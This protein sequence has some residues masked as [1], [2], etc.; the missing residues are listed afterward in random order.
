MASGLKARVVFSYEAGLQVVTISRSLPRAITTAATA[1]KR[2][3][4]HRH[5][6]RRGR[7]A[8]TVGVSTD[9]SPATA[10]V[11]IAPN[12][13]N[14]AG[15]SASTPLPESASS[16]P[17]SP[18]QP[19]PPLSSPEVNTPP[20]K[21]TRR[22]R[23]GVELLRGLVEE[24]KLLLSPLSCAALPLL[25]SLPSPCR[26]HTSLTASPRLLPP[27]LLELEPAS[28]VSGSLRRPLSWQHRLRQWRPLRG[29]CQPVRPH[30]RLRLS[31]HCCLRLS[32]QPATSQL[33]HR[34]QSTF[35]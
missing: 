8:K 3:R 24:G 17:Q 7:A 34:C 29:L 9:R 1:E 14:P 31:C 19:V 13:A 23:N 33:H 35:H 20:A 11:A 30:C 28:P 10:A 12:V 18:Q 21:W 26:S 22:R 4:S 15:K 32:L 5:C 6:R 16:T 27:A 25:F 2:C